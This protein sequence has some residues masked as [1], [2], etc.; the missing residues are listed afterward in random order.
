MLPDCARDISPGRD[1][2]DEIV[3]TIG[4][5]SF[6]APIFSSSNNSPQVRRDIER[7]AHKG[8]YRPHSV[9]AHQTWAW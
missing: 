4:A 2:A 6:V 8:V 3:D 1:W 7:A 9:G 5:I